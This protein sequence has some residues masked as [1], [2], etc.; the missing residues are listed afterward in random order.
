MIIEKESFKWNS[1]NIFYNFYWDALIVILIISV[2][3]WYFCKLGRKQ[4]AK[5][6]AEKEAEKEK[7]KEEKKPLVLNVCFKMLDMFKSHQRI[8]FSTNHVTV[9]YA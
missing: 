8:V 9:V 1:F 3:W 6:E 7:K 5:K 4:C 2:I